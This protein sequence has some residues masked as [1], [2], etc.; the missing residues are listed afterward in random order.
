MGDGD[1]G[2]ARAR[3]TLPA[4][5]RRRSL[6]PE[7][8]VKGSLDLQE[9]PFDLRFTIESL[10]LSLSLSLSTLHRILKDLHDVPRSTKCTVVWL[11]RTRFHKD[12]TSRDTTLFKNK[13]KVST[14]LGKACLPNLTRYRYVRFV[15]DFGNSGTFAVLRPAPVYAIISREFFTGASAFVS[16]RP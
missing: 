7:S 3:R 1:G 8:P 5:H 12:T 14:M 6:T 16:P 13:V 10:S 4:A 9:T 11:L 2:L 15:H